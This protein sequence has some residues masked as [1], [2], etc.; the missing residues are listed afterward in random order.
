[1]TALGFLNEVLLSKVSDLWSLGIY[2]AFAFCRLGAT[3]ALGALSRVV[4][5]IGGVLS[6]SVCKSFLLS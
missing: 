1:M 6:V 5:N 3:F 4:G 2:C